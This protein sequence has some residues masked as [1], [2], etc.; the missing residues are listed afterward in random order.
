MDIPVS[1]ENKFSNVVLAHPLCCVD[2]DDVRAARPSSPARQ[3]PRLRLQLPVRLWFAGKW[4]AFIKLINYCFLLNPVLNL[5]GGAK[6]IINGLG[7]QKRFAPTN[8]LREIG[9][10]NRITV[11]VSKLPTARSRAFFSGLD[12][13]KF[14]TSPDHLHQVTNQNCILSYLKCYYRHLLETCLIANAS[15]SWA[16]ESHHSEGQTAAAWELPHEIASALRHPLTCGRIIR[17]YT[18]TGCCRILLGCYVLVDMILK[19]IIPISRTMSAEQPDHTWCLPRRLWLP[20][21]A[22]MSSVL[23]HV[24]R[25]VFRWKKS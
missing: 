13:S 20:A 16:V 22:T 4:I 19:T 2:D 1:R 23:R 25:L 8:Y 21:T 9:K 17:H 24:F 14:T 12:G 7:A 18:L 10:R 11:T 6:N 3:R 5:G 15:T